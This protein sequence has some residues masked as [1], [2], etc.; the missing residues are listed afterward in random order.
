MDNALPREILTP[1]RASDD[2]IELQKA[3]RSLWRHKLLILG[4]I[5]TVTALSVIAVSLITPLYT[6][7]SLVVVESRNNE[8]TDINSVISGLSV[9]TNIIQT[10]VAMLRSESLAMKVVNQ[11]ILFEDAEFNPY[12][13][14]GDSLFPTAVPSTGN[15]TQKANSENW[16]PSE[17]V[18]NFL[19]SLTISPV[20]QS[21]VISIKF[22]SE[23][24]QKAALIAN[25]IAD[26][27]ITGQLEI[28][29]E[30]TR[31]AT[32]WLSQ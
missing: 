23:D 20:E 11:L 26:R 16:L 1:K 10:E 13:T 19:R 15:G 27:Y 2:D 24:P 29:F 14:S 18:G 3:L 31:R 25:T 30:A 22:E 28:K 4:V 21:Y 17:I 5:L 7:E 6:A 9:N 8:L 12:L 32:E